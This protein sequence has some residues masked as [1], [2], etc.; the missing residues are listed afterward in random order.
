VAGV[1]T[2][3]V[4]DFFGAPHRTGEEKRKIVAQVVGREITAFRAR[5][6]VIVYPLVPMF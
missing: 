6:I 2:E 1:S 3:A 5:E 4:D